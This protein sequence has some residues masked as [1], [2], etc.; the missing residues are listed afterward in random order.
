MEGRDVDVLEEG[1]GNGGRLDH[2]EIQTLFS[3]G[4]LFKRHVG[5]EEMAAFVKDIGANGDGDVDFEEF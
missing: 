4:K 3:S 5:K 2:D 1:D